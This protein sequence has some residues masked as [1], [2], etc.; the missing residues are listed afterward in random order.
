MWT[1]V[2]PGDVERR[3]VD[4]C[5]RSSQ[6]GLMK[7]VLWAWDGAKL[8]E[9]KMIVH[10]ILGPTTPDYTLTLPSSFHATLGIH[11]APD[12]SFGVRRSR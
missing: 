4:L 9:C 6:R 2:A 10:T 12:G 7:N 1:P 3:L 5:N 8:T 11:P